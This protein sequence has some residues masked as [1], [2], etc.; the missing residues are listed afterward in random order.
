M[1]Q[2]D[3]TQPKEKCDEINILLV[4]DDDIDA[5]GIK[6]AFKK[7]K[8]T[9][10]VTRARNGLEALEKLRSGELSKPR[11]VLLDIQMPK[12]NG[13]E[14]LKAIRDDEELKDTVVFVLTTSKSEEDMVAAYKKS[15]AGYIVKTEL[16]TSFEQLIQ[17]LRSYWRAIELP[18]K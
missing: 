16:D 4:E 18:K 3:T 7:Q 9:N 12:M 5:Q 2:V 17:L 13:L 10:P 14:F 8:I 15:I 1:D 6:R 11:I